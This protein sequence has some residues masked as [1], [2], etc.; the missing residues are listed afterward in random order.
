MDWI[1]KKQ[2]SDLNFQKVID[3]PEQLQWEP[4]VNNHVEVI[5]AILLSCQQLKTKKKKTE[6]IV[7]NGYAF[8]N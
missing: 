8:T 3:G 7:A 4:S 5:L 6:D 1:I 2:F